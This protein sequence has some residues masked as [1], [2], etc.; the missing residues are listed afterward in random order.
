MALGSAGLGA[1]EVEMDASG[2]SFPAGIVGSLEHAATARI[3]TIQALRKIGFMGFLFAERETFRGSG[4]KA[5]FFLLGFGWGGHRRGAFTER[6]ILIGNVLGEGHDG[7]EVLRSGG[8]FLASYAQTGVREPG[9]RYKAILLCEPCDPNLC[10]Q[11]PRQRRQLPYFFFTLGDRR[12]A[13]GGHPQDDGTT[14]IYGTRKNN[15]Y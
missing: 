2:V 9:D 3:A 5:E 14:E 10:D 11:G 13:A 7:R 1:G 4:L 8:A 15:F 6:S 12:A